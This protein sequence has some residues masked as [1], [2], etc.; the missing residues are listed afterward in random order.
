M[1]I[2]AEHSEDNKYK[3]NLVR[4]LVA[5]NDKSAPPENWE[6]IGFYALDDAG[7]LIGGVQ[8]NFEWDWLFVKHLWVKDSGK[9]IGRKLMEKAE[10][11]AKDKGK[12]G[13][14]LDTFSF[15]AKPFYEK[16]GFM[17][18]GTIEQ[19]AGTHSRYFM[20]KRI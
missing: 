9:G 12:T 10:T 4:G 17:V 1:K 15:Q 18:F 11:Y 13:V 19:A 14:L 6:F 2:I 7:K 16:I 3:K 20:M 8:G 5:Y